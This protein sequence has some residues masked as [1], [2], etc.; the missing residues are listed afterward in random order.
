ME[1]TPELEYGM[2]FGA[3][4]TPISFIKLYLEEIYCM[5][6]LAH[7]QQLGPDLLTI[8]IYGGFLKQS[9]EIVQDG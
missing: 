8:D 9:R 6:K 2:T 1:V 3:L 4:A 5:Y 7:V